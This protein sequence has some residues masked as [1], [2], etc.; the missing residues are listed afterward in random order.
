MNSVIG[1]IASQYSRREGLKRVVLD[2]YD[3]VTELH[4]YLNDY[5]NDYYADW[6]MLHNVKYYFGQDHYGD[7]ADN[8]KFILNPKEYPQSYFAT[9]DDDMYYPPDYV[10]QMVRAIRKLG[11]GTVIS[12]HGACLHV[13][14]KNYYNGRTVYNYESELL[15][16]V[17][18]HIVGTGCCMFST[19]LID[20]DIDEWLEAPKRMADIVLSSIAMRSG[21]DRVVLCHESKY[22]RCN[23][24]EA[25]KNSIA[26]TY[27]NNDSHIIEYINKFDWWK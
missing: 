3:Q 6:M 26:V 7:L 21:M 20:Y 22:L 9:F 25:Y 27:K 8:G 13:G 1:S 15:D 10:F 11:H 12:L 2:I 19:R 23:A 17:K 24:T 14:S 5:P 16:P 4:V 18:V